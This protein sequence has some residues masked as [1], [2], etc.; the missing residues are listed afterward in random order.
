MKLESLKSSINKVKSN[1]TVNWMSI[2]RIFIVLDMLFKTT[3]FLTILKDSNASKLIIDKVDYKLILVHLMY[4]ILVF[5]FG[6]LF[7]YKKQIIYYNVI[8]IIYSLLLVFDLSYFRVNRD[9]IGLKNILFPATFNPVKESLLNFRAIDFIFF[10]DMAVILIFIL[11]LKVKNH[12]KRNSNK[13]VVTFSVSIIGII[14]SIICLDIFSLAGWDK[15]IVNKG[16]TTLMSVEAPGPIGYH[17]NEAFTTIKRVVVPGRKS[18][19]EEIDRWLE[20]N[21]ENLPDNEY[22]GIA[23]GKNVVFIQVESLENFVINEK[24]NG[25]EITPV[26]NR[27]VQNGLYFSN[28]YEQNNAGNSIDCDYMTNTSIL[29]LGGRIT[30][31]NY[32]ELVYPNSLSRVL[33]REGY[34]TISTHP[35]KPN[36]FNW[37]ELHRNGFGSKEIWD[38]TDYVYEE[39]VGY[40][41]SDKSFFSQ[42]AKK[43]KDVEKPFYIHAPTSSSHGPFNI[44]D[45]YRKL[46]LPEYVDESYLGG[47]F[48]SIHYTDEQIGMFIKTLEEEGLLKDTM[49]VIYGDHGGVH[50]YYNDDIKDLDYENG[51]WKGYTQE[52]PLIIYADGIK[53]KEFTVHGGHVDI[54]PTVLYL[55]G[56]EDSKYRNTSM[57]RVLVNTNRDSTVIKGNILMGNYKTEEEREHILRAYDIGEKIIKNDYFNYRD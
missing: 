25:K 37:T 15:K 4:I 32:G 11:I 51:W 21:N 45:E 18:D 7:S 22:K 2:F 26:M 49:I 55:L 24:T 50:K 9:F 44:A 46:D 36:E 10:A 8:N 38:I 20:A 12:E 43:L 42:V 33:N 57:G 56:I 30:S 14:I 47:Y 31:L 29:P 6:Y 35:L 48:E 19:I 16:W 53:E 39:N 5:S 41:L 54:M 23:K 3:I 27:I 1:I 34:E 13:F 40:G 52:I 28:V 17:L